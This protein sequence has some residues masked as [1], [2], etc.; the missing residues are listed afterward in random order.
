MKRILHIFLFLIGFQSN[1]AQVQFE[2]KVSKTT[3]GLNETLRVDFSMNA[4]GD[5]FSTPNFEGFRVVG[6]PSQQISQSWVNGRSSFAK[7]YSY[8]LLPLQKGILTIKPAMIEINGQVYK[9]NPVKITVTNAIPKPRDPNQQPQLSADTELHL[10]A[11]ISNANPYI[12]Q[13]VTVVYKLYFSNNI[14]ISNFNETNKPKYKDFWSQNIE[15]KELVAEQTTFKGEA[16][17]SIVL[18]KVILYP[19]KSGN[20]II[21][22]LA[23]NIDVQLPTGRRDIFGQMQIVEDSKIVSAGNKT[24]NVKPLPETGKPEEFT[25]AAGKFEFTVTPSKTSLKHGESLVLEVKASGTGNLKLFS[26][27]KPEVPTALEMFDPEHIENITTPLS[28]DQG[29]ISDK[30]TIVPQF[31]GK[32]PIKPMSFSYFDFGSQSYK[33]ITSK[34]I[35]I[36]VIDGPTETLASVKSNKDKI[37]K[38]N[39]NL[40]FKEIIAKTEL[41]NIKRRD[42]LYS[43]KFYLLMF[44]PFFMIPMIIF[45]RKRKE[46]SDNDSIGNRLK[47]N[48]KLAKKYLSQAKKQINNKEQFYV[49]LEKAMHNFLKAKLK[50]ETSEMSKENIEKLL[51]SNNANEISVS[52]FINLTENCEIARYAPSTK[53]T[54]EQDY[55]KAVL[56]IADLEKQINH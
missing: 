49:A 26:L 53:A 35:M 10:I 11:D 12:N 44:A 51:L 29:S 41:T 27:P 34:E 22:P 21:E 37:A 13:P 48:N 18:K 17:R 25:G 4:D 5:N 1:V 42:F 36:D 20:L 8:Y 19:Q 46:N 38:A 55:E 33:T 3:L 24:L 30:Y 7:A 47:M 28:G 40:V 45:I 56:I 50:I 23:L 31:K 6:G 2:C 32:Y 9:T 54:I 39:K 52:E 16:Y 15:I 43:T 14:G